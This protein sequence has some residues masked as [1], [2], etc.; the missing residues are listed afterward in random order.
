MVY[1]HLGGFFC[2]A[3]KKICMQKDLYADLYA[4]EINLII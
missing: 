1:L 2:S 3:Y 4:A